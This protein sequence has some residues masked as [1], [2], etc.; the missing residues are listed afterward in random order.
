MHTFL[1]IGFLVAL[2]YTFIRFARQENIQEFYEEVVLDVE[3]RL[4]WAKTRRFFPFGMQAQLEVSHKLLYDAK[5]LWQQNKWD[6]AYHAAIQSQ[7]AMNRAQRI[8]STVLMARQQ[9]ANDRTLE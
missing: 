7:E 1:T 6:Q 4:E 9:S 2:F 8:Y 5:N 3:G